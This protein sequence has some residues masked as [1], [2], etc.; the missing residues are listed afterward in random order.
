M[1]GMRA[2]QA[3]QLWDECS[4]QTSVILAAATAIFLHRMGR[5]DIYSSLNASGKSQCDFG[6]PCSSV[7]PGS[8]IGARRQILGQMR[9][10]PQQWP[11]P[12]YQSVLQMR[13]LQSC[14]T[15]WAVS[16]WT[17]SEIYWATGKPAARSFIL[18]V[19]HDADN[20]L[21]TAHFTLSL[22]SLT[23]FLPTPSPQLTSC[24]NGFL[25]HCA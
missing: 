15:Y 13:L 20:S 14:W 3:C 19:W 4:F 12:Y 16:L 21:L 17:S 1:R 5:P 11:S 2:A 18:L 9:R 25:Y 24:L 10:S 7:L 23:S 22:I 6:F 8:W